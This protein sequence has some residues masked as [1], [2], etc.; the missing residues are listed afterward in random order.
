MV[1]LS[2]SELSLHQQ[3]HRTK[4]Y[5]TNKVKSLNGFHSDQS[6]KVVF[7]FSFIAIV[8][9]IAD[10]ERFDFVCNNGIR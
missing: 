1:E 8:N 5:C 10:L 6:V 3:K 4:D 2:L 9:S 7:N